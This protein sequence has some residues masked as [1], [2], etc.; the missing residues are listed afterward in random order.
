MSRFL[1]DFVIVR[2][3]VNLVHGFL[4]GTFLGVMGVHA[5]VLWGC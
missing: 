1:I 3:E 4:F 2:T 5:A